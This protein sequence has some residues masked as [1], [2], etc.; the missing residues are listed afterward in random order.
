[1]AATSELMELELPPDNPMVRK[2]LQSIVD[3]AK[4]V[5][6]LSQQ[7]SALVKALQ[8]RSPGTGSA[9]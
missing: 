6:Q 3:G 4:R 2:R 8:R 9:T 5:D 1:M 7:V